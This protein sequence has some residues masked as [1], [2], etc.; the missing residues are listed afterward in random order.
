MKS[1]RY[2]PG[3]LLL[4]SIF[5]VSCVDNNEN[6][7]PVRKFVTDTIVTVQQVKALY[8]DQLALNYKLRIPVEIVHG[9]ALSGIITASDKK[10]GNLYKEAFIQDATGGLRLLFESTSGLYIGDSVIVNLKGLYIGDYGDFWQVGGEP[11]VDDSGSIRVSGMNMDKQVLKLSINNPTYPDTITVAQAKS[12][13][14][15]GKLVALKGV[16]FTDDAVNQTYGDLSGEAPASANR[17]LMDCDK[18]KIIVRTSG[19]ASFADDTISDMNGTIT[20]IVTIFSSDY[21]LIIR[22]FKEVKLTNDR[23]WP[24]IPDLG[25][26]VETIYLNFEGFPNN[27]DLKITGWQNIAQYGDRVWRS[28]YKNG[29]NYSQA[30]GYNSSLGSMVAWLITRP[31]SISTQKVL[32]FQTAK[33]YWAHKG[34]NIP[35]QVFYSTDY[36]GKNLFTA[37]WIPINATIAGYNDA[38]NTFISSGNINLPIQNGKSCVIAFKYTGSETEST[39]FRIDNISVTT[40]R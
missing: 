1:K 15:L 21:Q 35:F 6:D 38:D 39:S 32:S 17:D 8:K 26:P 11:Y 10:D 31:V 25:T 14:Y 40:V 20:G 28:M 30:T 36:T 12:S 4:I 22:D 16:Q 24:G 33:E 37:T 13:A 5:A 18:K 7:P 34:N 9:W 2:I 29:L 27:T 3:L 19:Y 23:C